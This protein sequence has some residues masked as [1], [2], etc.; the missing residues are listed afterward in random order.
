MVMNFV[1]YSTDSSERIV[2][3]VN[4]YFSSLDDIRVCDNMIWLKG[5]SLK[6]YEKLLTINVFN[7]DTNWRQF[8]TEF[9]PKILYNEEVY[10]SSGD[11][12]EYFEEVNDKTE[13]L[14]FL[15]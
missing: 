10:L 13:F 9:L 12:S 7:S 11:R 6:F 3:R 2:S 15:S 1:L 8:L 4:N 14:R 5:M